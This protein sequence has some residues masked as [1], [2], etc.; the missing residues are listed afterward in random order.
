[1]VTIHNRDRPSS[2]QQSG[3][4]AVTS[5]L[6]TAAHHGTDGEQ[7]LVVG[8]GGDV[9]KADAS[10]GSEREVERCDVA[11]P[12]VRPTHTVVGT[13]RRVVRL[14]Q[15]MQPADWLVESRLLYLRYEIPA[16]A[17]TQGT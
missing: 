15:V 10:D 1:M 17:H 12:R 6:L 8:V 14:G 13:E 4:Q 7:L 16:H 2:R 11:R 5:S 9:A 3:K